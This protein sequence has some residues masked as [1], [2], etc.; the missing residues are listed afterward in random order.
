MGND[1]EDDDDGENPFG[2]SSECADMFQFEV[3][4]NHD[5]LNFDKDINW[6]A[7]EV[8]LALESNEQLK[9]VK[10][11]MDECPIKTERVEG[12]MQSLHLF[13]HVPD[14]QMKNTTMIFLVQLIKAHL[15][16]ICFKLSMSQVIDVEQSKFGFVY[17]SKSQTSCDDLETNLLAEFID[18][19]GLQKSYKET[20]KHREEKRRNTIS[21]MQDAS[22]EKVEEVN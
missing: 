1:D 21:A 14:Q 5:E 8:R 6:D 13:F 15:Q 11:V 19:D 16:L 22:K 10:K 18:Y 3:I 9:P 7:E 20:K 2:T 12:S 17:N 4:F